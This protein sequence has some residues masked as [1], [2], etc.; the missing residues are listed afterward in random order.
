LKTTSKQLGVLFKK[1]KNKV[2]GKEPVE[3]TVEYIEGFEEELKKQ[4]RTGVE[5]EERKRRYINK[6][7]RR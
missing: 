5:E 7:V 1:L 4:N 6:S 3:S 2:K